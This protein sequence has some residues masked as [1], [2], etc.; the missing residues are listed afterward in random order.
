MYIPLQ[1]SQATFW[2]WFNYNS[3]IKNLNAL[4]QPKEIHK[5]T[6]TRNNGDNYHKTKEVIQVTILCFFGVFWVCFFVVW[7]LGFFK[8]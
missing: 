4:T 3:R 2:G 8:K 7:V 6:K 5:Y 1:I